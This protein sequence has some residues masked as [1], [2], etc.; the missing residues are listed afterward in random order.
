MSNQQ[1]TGSYKWNI[2][3]QQTGTSFPGS[4]DGKE[5]AHNAGDMDSI[6]GLER[7]PR[8]RNRYSVFLPG[9]FHGQG[10]LASYSLWGR[11]QLDMT[12]QL[13]NRNYRFT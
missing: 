7:S 9:E 8:E 5:S 6:P 11:K 10:S 12:E 1:V 4:S 13:T 3:L 2:I